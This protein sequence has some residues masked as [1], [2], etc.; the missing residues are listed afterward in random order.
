[1]IVKLNLLNIEG[2]KQTNEIYDSIFLS[3]GVLSTLKI[4]DESID[5]SNNFKLLDNDLYL[6]P[7]INFEG[8][9]EKLG[10]NFTLNQLSIRL[11]A[12]GT[13][14]HIQ[15]YNMSNTIIDRFRPTPK[16][17]PKLFSGNYAKLSTEYIY[18]LCLFS[19]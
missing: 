18:T 19:K 2:N 12:E 8:S 16:S 15:L 14:C 9:R 10:V 17:D 7:C 3:T 6:I 13:P 1:M 5:T 11:F 4:I